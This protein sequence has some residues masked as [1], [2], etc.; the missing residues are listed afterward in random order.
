MNL[1]EKTLFLLK[2]DDFRKTAPVHQKISF[3][4]FFLKKTICAKNVVKTFSEGLEYFW[5]Y[6]NEAENVYYLYLSMVSH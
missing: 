3:F 4:C 6:Q 2:N 1:E 5:R